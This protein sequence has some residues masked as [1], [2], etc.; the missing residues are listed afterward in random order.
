MFA[1]SRRA[2]STA[3]ILLTCYGCR[4]VWDCASLVGRA[5]IMA[6][7]M[8]SECTRLTRVYCPNTYRGLGRAYFVHILCIFFSL[9]PFG[10]GHGW[11][12]G[13]PTLEALNG[14]KPV[15]EHSVPSSDSGI[16]RMDRYRQ[17]NPPTVFMSV[18]PVSP[19]FFI[20]AVH[21]LVDESYRTCEGF[22]VLYSKQ[23]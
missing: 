8:I 16:G 3:V 5:F 22:T 11:N 9:P 6:K 7:R 1:A 19:L 4:R 13:N 10:Q 12:T 18:F 2:L 20:G 14:V 17:R 15:N 23:E 21:Q